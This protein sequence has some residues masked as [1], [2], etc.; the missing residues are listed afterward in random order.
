MRATKKKNLWTADTGRADTKQ[1]VNHLKNFKMHGTSEGIHFVANSSRETS[2]DVRW[3]RTREQCTPSMWEKFPTWSSTDRWWKGENGK[4]YFWRNSHKHQKPPGWSSEN[5]ESNKTASFKRSIPGNGFTSER[6]LSSSPTG[7]SKLVLADIFKNVSADWNRW[8]A[9]QRTTDWERCNAQGMTRSVNRVLS[10]SPSPFRLPKTGATRD[11]SSN[12][13]AWLRSVKDH[14][15]GVGGKTPGERGGIITIDRKISWKDQA[16]V[17]IWAHGFESKNRTQISRIDIA[18][19][20]SLDVNSFEKKFPVHKNDQESLASPKSRKERVEDAS[21]GDA[22]T[23]IAD[24]RCMG[25]ENF[26][27]DE[28]VLMSHASTWKAKCLLY[29]TRSRAFKKKKKIRKEGGHKNSKFSKRLASW[30]ATLLSRK[31]T[32]SVHFWSDRWIGPDPTIRIRQKS[33]NTKTV[34]H[35]QQKRYMHLAEKK[36]ANFQ[37]KS[38]FKVQTSF[39]FFCFW[40]ILFLVM[41]RIPS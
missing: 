6:I 13:S 20:L 27:S 34:K 33:P 22:N 2:W 26:Q 7:L 8:N 18:R 32:T 12:S 3:S 28:P 25:S 11:T 9:C 39:G 16:S 10:I 17:S 37:A 15:I 21:Q 36:V 41:V 24:G 30:P 4:Q 5:T 40:K 23:R 35:F 38:L 14:S 31:K 19:F 1:E 29:T